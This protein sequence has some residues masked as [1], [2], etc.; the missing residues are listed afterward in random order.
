MQHA[1]IGSQVREID[2]DTFRLRA[3]RSYY[4]EVSMQCLDEQGKLLDQIIDLAFDTLDARHLDLRIVDGHRG[5][6]CG[7]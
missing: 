7:A 6:C 4:A 5:A 2:R 3:V 1:Q